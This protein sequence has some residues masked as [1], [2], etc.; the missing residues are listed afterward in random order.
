MNLVRIKLKDEKNIKTILLISIFILLLLLLIFLVFNPINFIKEQ[1]IKKRE[2]SLNT[3]PAYESL[4]NIQLIGDV[5][6]SFPVS[7]GS[8]NIENNIIK[9]NADTNTWVRSVDDGIIS[10][11]GTNNEYGNY[12]E[13]E[14][15]KMYKDDVY[16]FYGNLN[17]RINGEVIVIQNGQK[18]GEVGDSGY[19]TFEIRD[20]NHNRLNPYK[21]MILP[22]D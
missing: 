21:Y 13:I 1:L 12:I 20:K 14:C 9:I 22:D 16:L 15:S 8:F 2:Q 7:N 4:K 10:D 17:K 6:Y 19:I 3:T 11:I 5:K 18:L